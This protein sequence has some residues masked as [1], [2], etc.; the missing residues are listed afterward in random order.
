MAYGPDVARQE[1]IK[2]ARENMLHNAGKAA[3]GQKAAQ[4]TDQ[5]RRDWAEEM[6]KTQPVFLR[7]SDIQG[8]YDFSRTLQTT[9]G[10]VLR[11]ITT[12]DLQ[13]FSRNIEML[14][15]RY[16]GGI[17]PRNVIEFSL[18]EDRDR[19]NEEIFLCSPFSRKAG[20]VRFITN[21]SE[22]SKDKRHYVSVQFNDYSRFVT[23][24]RK[25]NAKLTRDQL[26][27]TSIKFDCDCG[28]HTYW[29]RYIAT[30]AG[31]ALGRQENAFP[32]IRNPNLYGVA[33]KH[34]L[35][36]MQFILSPLGVQYL[37]TQVDKDRT[38]QLGAVRKETEKQMLDRLLQLESTAHH[39]RQ[40]V[41]T[42]DERPGYSRQQARRLAAAEARQQ[43]DQ[44]AKQQS[45]FTR[46][47]A[48]D[49]LNAIK[50]IISTDLYA[51]ALAGI[52]SRYPE[53]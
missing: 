45:R 31:Y 48:L 20:V 23:S 34:V 18:K 14:Q 4:K 7:P 44:A 16:K 36:V 17:S 50:G 38:G 40:R 28:R 46:Q 37:R 27:G 10:G 29:F 53:V 6:D 9:L 41:Q 22:G 47:V 26:V 12:A 11:P 13:A 3:S 15:D 39:Q 42:R 19:A 21:A 49:E 5:K 30:A 51:S 2:R 1:A 8:D 35:R 52:N 25:P 33:C 43:A 32:K 24:P